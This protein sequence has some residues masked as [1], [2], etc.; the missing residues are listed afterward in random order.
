[1]A[2][3]AAS[4][5][6]D[7]VPPAPSYCTLLPAQ[8]AL[9]WSARFPTAALMQAHPPR[10]WDRGADA[11]NKS[12]VWKL[13]Q[14]REPSTRAPAGSS[15]DGMDERQLRVARYDGA[16]MAMDPAALLTTDTQLQ[17][18]RSVYGYEEPA[19]PVG[20]CHWWTNFA[21]KHLFA[22]Y[23]SSLFAQ[24]EWQCLEIPSLCC[25]REFMAWRSET[26]PMAI[27]QTVANSVPTPVLV[28]NAPREVAI[29][30]LGAK[31]Y[32][33]SFC[34]AKS[35]VID[36][37]TTLLPRPTLTNIVAMEALKHRSGLYTLRDVTVTL[38]T[39]V[40]AFTAA[41]EQA[42]LEWKTRKLLTEPTVVVH[43]GNWSIH[44]RHCREAN[45]DRRWDE[46][47]L[48]LISFCSFSVLVLQLCSA[49]AAVRSVATP[50]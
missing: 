23:A 42:T 25:L 1:M 48:K 41:K 10:G 13:I 34:V 2:A 9:L 32:G 50:S 40:T 15:A 27:P 14:S 36:A 24:D 12:R 35:S 45:S 16:Q 39:A 46:S 31:I 29:D 22:F 44:E 43:T 8:S 21:D 37:A 26:E 11:C 33:N 17:I 7:A 18:V 38:Q 19:D 49:G 28:M 30:A 6:A 20:E 3:P 4:S 5:A 47:S